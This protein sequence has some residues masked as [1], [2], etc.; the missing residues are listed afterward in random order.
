MATDPEDL[1]GW[2]KIFRSL[3]EHPL[4]FESNPVHLKVFVWCLFRAR[5]KDNGV[6]KRG[7]FRT[8][9]KQGS[10]ALG[11]SE[12]AF[13]RSIKR[14]EELG[15]ISIDVNNL[16]SVVTVCNY[17][18][19]QN[20]EDGGRTTTTCKSEQVVNRSK[21][22]DQRT[23]GDEVANGEQRSNS[24]RTA[25]EHLKKKVKKGKK[26]S[27][28]WEEVPEETM[29]PIPRKVTQ[30][31]IPSMEEIRTYAQ[32]IK[33]QSEP[34]GFFDYFEGREW[35]FNGGDRVKNW[36]AAFRT[37]ER[38]HKKFSGERSANGHHNGNG[39]KLLPEEPIQDNIP[40][41]NGFD[42]EFFR[43]MSGGAK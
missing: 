24:D 21:S 16:F 4:W 8:G 19:Y 22:N 28:L 6:L 11:I 7:Q 35:R 41:S 3:E 25:S 36:Q 14:L 43:R 23:Y 26:E 2:L 12:S 13:Y 10:S 42:P 15:C 39:Q 18:T 34:E 38:N 40:K 32:E 1:G 9:R 37:W 17:S 31:A 20:E 30:Y 5:W 27:V 29:E 33:A